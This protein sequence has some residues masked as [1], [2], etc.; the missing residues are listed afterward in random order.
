GAA[1]ARDR[2]PVRR[3]APRRVAPP[4]AG[5]AGRDDRGRRAAARRAARR[6][7]RRGARLPRRA[8]LTFMPTMRAMRI[9]AWGGPP[10]LDELPEPAPRPGRSLVRMAATTASHLD[11]SIAAGGF[12]R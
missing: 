6:V 1:A 8:A 10:R 5:G 4:A 7:R 12:L 11:R 3:A 9:H 2:R